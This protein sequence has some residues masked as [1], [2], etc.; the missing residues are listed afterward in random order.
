[1]AS[2]RGLPESNKEASFPSNVKGTIEEDSDIQEDEPYEAENFNSRQTINQGAIE[3][4]E[5]NNYQMVRASEMTN[6]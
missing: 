2:A 4:M 3:T 6:Y 1:M 5:S